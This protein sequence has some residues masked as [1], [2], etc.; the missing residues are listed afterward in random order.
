VNPV[1]FTLIFAVR[2][3]QRVLSPGKALLFGP[4]GGCRFEPS[5]SQYAVE[6]IRLH[7]AAAGSWLALKR[8]LRCH[9]AG[10]CGWDP[11]PEKTG[12]ARRTPMFHDRS[13]AGNNAGTY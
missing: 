2:V 3:Y 7:G 1:Q 12:T 13:K 5:C 8:L 9:P 4:L 6:A 10:G 11:V